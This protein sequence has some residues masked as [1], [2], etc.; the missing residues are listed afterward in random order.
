MDNVTSGWGTASEAVI[1]PTAPSVGIGAAFISDSDG[2]SSASLG[3]PQDSAQHTANDQQLPSQHGS[4]ASIP[5]TAA[6][7]A[8]RAEDDEDDPDSEAGKRKH[9]RL[10]LIAWVSLVLAVL[11]WSIMGP[12]FVYLNRKGV[13]PILAAAWRHQ[14][15]VMFVL[16]PMLIEYRRFP[17]DRRWRW[18]ARFEELDEEIKGKEA[19]R[20]NRRLS[21]MRLDA[22]TT[23]ASASTNDA[24]ATAQTQ[25]TAITPVEEANYGYSTSSVMVTSPSSSSSHSSASPTS[26]SS[27]STSSVPVARASASTGVARAHV[28]DTIAAPSANDDV[29]DEYANDDKVYLGS[30]HTRQSDD[31]DEEV[32]GSHDS[33]TSNSSSSS[34]SSDHKKS[35]GKFVRFADDVEEFSGD[36]IDD[37]ETGSDR[38]TFSSSSSPRRV[39]RVRH[40]QHCAALRN[41]ST[42][43][44]T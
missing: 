24:D 25:S 14:A 19:A 20:M 12:S 27:S 38:R 28:V 26:S 37:L 35:K 22:N 2:F 21:Q 30:G 11:T 33:N 5:A 8:A 17:K 6:D 41:V 29:D 4:D 43:R 42:R 1:M 34:S 39:H 23:Q 16:I 32:D 18:F 10:V 31:V 3:Y 13:Q 7:S 9:R 40:H 36:T 44:L 15:V